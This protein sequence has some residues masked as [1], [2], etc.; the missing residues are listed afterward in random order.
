[1]GLILFRHVEILLIHNLLINSQMSEIE[2][3]Q[4]MTDLCAIPEF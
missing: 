1:M 4:S 3:E 2:P